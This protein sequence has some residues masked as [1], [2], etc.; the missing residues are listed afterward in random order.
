MRQHSVIGWLCLSVVSIKFKQFLH[1]FSDV[2]G[3]PLLRILSGFLQKSLTYTVRANL[4]WAKEEYICNIPTI[5][6]I[7]YF[8]FFVCKY[9]KVCTILANFFL[10]L[11]HNYSP[12]FISAPC[13]PFIKLRQSIGFFPAGCTCRISSMLLFNFVFKIFISTPFIFVRPHPSA[14]I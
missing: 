2:S 8:L 7:V 1:F 4:L 5:A 14:R 12:Y 9:F 10:Y 11:W 6:Q 3:I 13:R